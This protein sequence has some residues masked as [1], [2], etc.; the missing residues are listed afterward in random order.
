MSYIGGQRRYR[1]GRDMAAPPIL[2]IG[3]MNEFSPE[4]GDPL[5]PETDAISKEWKRPR[6]PWAEAP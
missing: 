3:A 4:V 1:K 2:Q 6:L 5:F